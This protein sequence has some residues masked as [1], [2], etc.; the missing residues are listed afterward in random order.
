[1]EPLLRETSDHEVD[2]RMPLSDVVAVILDAVGVD[3]A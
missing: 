1:V 2:S 3:D